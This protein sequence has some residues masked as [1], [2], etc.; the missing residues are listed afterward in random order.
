MDSSHPP[1]DNRG[2]EI[3]KDSHF[4]ALAFEVMDNSYNDNK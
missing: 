4:L 1:E 3:L 2:W